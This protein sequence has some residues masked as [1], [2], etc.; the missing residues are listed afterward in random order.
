MFKKGDK[1][2]RTTGTHEDMIPGEI[3]TVE[4]QNNVFEL[5]LEGYNSAHNPLNFKLVEEEKEEMFGKK[6][7]KTGHIIELVTFNKVQFAM[8]LM[9]TANG[10]IVAGETWF[11][12]SS[13]ADED[14][15]GNNGDVKINRVYCPKTNADHAYAITRPLKD[16]IPHCSIVWERKEKTEQ[17]KQIEE[18]EKTILLAKQQIEELKKS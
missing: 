18:L 1:V 12:L 5:Y 10:D 16:Q 11:P 14:L 17:Q 15:F 3:A 2:Q 4:A 6:D 13:Y 9:G 7:L 8:V